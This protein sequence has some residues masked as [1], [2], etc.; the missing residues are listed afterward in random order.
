MKL[1]PIKK[2]PHICRDVIPDP[3]NIKTLI[4][5]FNNMEELCESYN[6]A[7]LAAPQVGIPLKMV[8]VRQGPFEYNWL[9]NGRYSGNGLLTSSTESCLSIKNQN[10]SLRKFIVQRFT[11]IQV[12][13][14]QLYKD[15]KKVSPYSNFYKELTGIEAII[16]Q[17]E[18]DH[19]SSILI[20]QIGIEVRE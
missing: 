1:V 4:N 8:V 7:G 15:I 10:G 11:Q 6:G 3:A 9:L 12:D 5:V 14:I 19:C 18:I 16:Y 20:S 17:H 2:I 13:G